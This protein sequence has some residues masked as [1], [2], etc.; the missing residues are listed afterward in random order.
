MTFLYVV[1]GLPLFQAGSI[2]LRGLRHYPLKYTEIFLVFQQ[3]QNK[4]A[5]YKGTEQNINGKLGFVYL[6]AK[7]HMNFLYSILYTDFY[8]WKYSVCKHWRRDI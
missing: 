8:R 4:N 3:E 2:I 5:T 7:C 1:F 6:F